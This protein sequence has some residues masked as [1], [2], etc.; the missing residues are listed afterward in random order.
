M[1]SM[2]SQGDRSEDVAVVFLGPSVKHLQESDV[3]DGALIEP[4]FQTRLRKG[5][6]RERLIPLP[7]EVVNPGEDH[8]FTLRLP[9]IFRAHRIIAHRSVAELFDIVDF[10]VGRL[11]QFALHGPLPAI[12]FEETT[13]NIPFDTAIIGVEISMVVR[14]T[15]D[16]ARSFIGRIEGLSLE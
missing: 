11:S 9:Y 6:H 5:I 14:N 4:T 10:K 3:Q 7:A 16:Q 13:P 1:P 2:S 15:S 12:L 8:T